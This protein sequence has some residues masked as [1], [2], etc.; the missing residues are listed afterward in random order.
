MITSFYEFPTFINAPSD[1]D[2][3]DQKAEKAM[4]TTFVTISSMSRGPTRREILESL[5]KFDLP[6]QRN[7]GAFC[8]DKKDVLA[9]GKKNIIIF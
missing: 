2:E 5:D 8:S 7:E 1:T 4:A 3:D 6:K 9:K